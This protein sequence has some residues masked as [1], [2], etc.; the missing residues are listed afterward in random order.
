MTTTSRAPDGASTRRG[1]SFVATFA[2]VMLATLGVFQVLQGLVAVVGDEIY[3]TT[4]DYTYSFDITQWGWIHMAIGV[5]AI[6]VGLGIF[7]RQNWAI[8]AGIACA[9]FSAI[10][11]FLFL[12]HYPWWSMLVIA[13]DVLVI[14]ALSV[15][16]SDAGSS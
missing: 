6:V 14:W 10:N 3:V 13:F 12:P 8:V 5:I 9:V 4:P 11:N 1:A 7:A 2:G 15:H 16:L